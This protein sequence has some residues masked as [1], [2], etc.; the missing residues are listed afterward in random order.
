MRVCRAA[1]V[2]ASACLVAAALLLV[3]GS[4]AAH[5]LGLSV[6]SYQL[7][8][9]HRRA[10]MTFRTEDAVLAVGG[11]DSNG[12]GHVS[13]L[14]I[15]RARPAL[16]ADFI[17]GLTVLSDGDPCHPTLDEAALEGPDGLSLTA[18]Y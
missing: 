8:G 16:E 11:L 3:V 6:G 1:L 4:A 9:G 2:W 13:D 12:D 18:R 15:A 7:N 5:T 14:E 10:I 17:D